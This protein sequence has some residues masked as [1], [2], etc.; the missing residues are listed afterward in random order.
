D[1]EPG[2]FT[3]YERHAHQHVVVAIRGRGEVRLGERWEPVG[4][5]DIVYVAPNEPHQFRAAGDEA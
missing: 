1:V 5:G 2:G 4:Y 3:T